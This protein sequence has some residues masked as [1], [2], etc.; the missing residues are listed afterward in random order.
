MRSVLTFP[1]GRRAKWI[2]F[3]A[4]I[5]L[6]FA[7][8][9]LNLPGKFADAE[10]NESS[11]FLPGDAESTRALAVTKELQGAETVQTV[12]VF[13]RAGGLTP[14]D[15]AYIARVEREL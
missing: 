9:A 3:G 15:G 14:G 11:S 7:I 5:V 4:W 8:S 12:V 1:A 2:I 6:I 13:R 10:K